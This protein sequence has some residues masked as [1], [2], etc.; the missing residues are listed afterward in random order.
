MN[1]NYKDLYLK[2]KKKYLNFKKNLYGG[3]L[4]KA[5]KKN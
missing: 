4:S 5:E 3:A 1:Q 2:Y